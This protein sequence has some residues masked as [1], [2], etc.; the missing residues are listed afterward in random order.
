MI[1]KLLIYII[2]LISFTSSQQLS[3]RLIR[4]TDLKRQLV[5]DNNNVL[6]LYDIC[7]D[8]SRNLAY[9]SGIV[10]RYVSC[11]NLISR[12]ETHTFRLP[13]SEQLHILKCNPT[14]GYLLVTTVQS[15]PVKSYLIRSDNGEVNGSVN[16]NSVISGTSFHRSSNRI[17]ISEGLEIKIFNG[18]NLSLI[19]SINT[20]FEAGGCEIDS[21][22]NQIYVVSKNII[23]GNVSVK[24]FLINSPYSLIRTINLP[25]SHNNGDIK[26]DPARNRFYLIGLRNLKVVN[27]STGSIV[28]QVYFSEDV[29]SPVYD[30]NTATL[31]LT[32]DDG[33]SSNSHNGL[34]S[35]IYKYNTSANHL[36]SFLMGDKASRLS[37][38][39]LGNTLLLP[40][41]HSG[42]VQL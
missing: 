36:D 37:F 39:S 18:S 34:W 11:I 3:Y 25:S 22:N 27:I 40:N 4:T 19:S 7:V 29:S 21:V 28:N 26:I 15:S 30:V 38:Y 2:F 13:F 8:E 23:S 33:Y 20:M 24:V 31:Y 1:S 41:M 6:K 17:F 5:S 16:H 35:K 42:L 10:T 32:D 12:T 9:T 14:N